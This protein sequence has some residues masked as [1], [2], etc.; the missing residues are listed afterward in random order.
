[1]LST[2]EA[3]RDI[4]SYKDEVVV[5]VDSSWV[6]KAGSQIPVKQQCGPNAA[7]VWRSVF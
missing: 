7:H 4:D 1:M 5:C 6:V 3:G 2:V